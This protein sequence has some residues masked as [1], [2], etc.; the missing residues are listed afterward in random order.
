MLKA[1]RE[2]RVLGARC[3]GLGKNTGLSAEDSESSKLKAQRENKAVMR[4]K[5]QKAL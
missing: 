3:L 5:I 1:Q 4:G 2:D